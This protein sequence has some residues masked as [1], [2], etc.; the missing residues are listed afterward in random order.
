[1]A[2]IQFPPNVGGKARFPKNPH[3]FNRVDRNGSFPIED[4]PQNRDYLVNLAS[5]PNPHGPDVHGVYWQ[6]EW[7]TVNKM[8]VQFWVSIK[9]GTIQ[10]FGA[11]L[12]ENQYHFNN[13]TSKWT[14]NFLD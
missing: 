9:N 10:N 6:Q 11:N 4:T 12:P 2:E 14:K 1:M 3:G 5:K 13:N 7:M 8:Q